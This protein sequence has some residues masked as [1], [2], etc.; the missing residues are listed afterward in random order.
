MSCSFIWVS[1]III[2]SNFKVLVLIDLNT[3]QSTRSKE[4]TIIIISLIYLFCERVHVF[5]T[6][7]LA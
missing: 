1:T 7:Y 3:S 4:S 6:K 2:L 5:G